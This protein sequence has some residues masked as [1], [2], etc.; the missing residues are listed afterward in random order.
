MNMRVIQ[1]SCALVVVSASLAFAQHA[2][3]RRP[4][5]SDV[6]RVSPSE[7]RAD[8]ATYAG[9]SR[10]DSSPVT[11]TGCVVRQGDSSAHPVGSDTP[12]GGTVADTNAGA[13]PTGSA[14]AGS[15]NRGPGND[16]LLLIVT[17][18]RTGTT[19]SGIVPGSS[20]SPGDTGTIPSQTH[21]GTSTASRSAAPT[22]LHLLFARGMNPASYVGQRVEV[23]GVVTSNSGND[24]TDANEVTR[25]GEATTGTRAEVGRDR[26]AHP[27]AD[28][29]NLKVQTI[30]RISGRCE[31]P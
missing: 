20:P 27:S 8:P 30:K 22:A 29:S 18:S 1:S 6:G 19:P 12:G 5:T 14:A 26:D 9:Q 24:A 15:V 11:M 25:A 3:D 28:L 23:R 4:A 17:A 13:A 16:H 21:A 7:R 2:G 31:T 10:A